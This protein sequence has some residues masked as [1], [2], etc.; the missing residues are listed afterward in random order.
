MNKH[1]KIRRE[2]A[3][4]DK[5]NSKYYYHYYI[6]VK[7]I[8][9]VLSVNGCNGLKIFKDLIGDEYVIINNEIY[10]LKGKDKIIK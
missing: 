3:K 4:Y 2:R 8:S 7:K 5:K 1:R 9:Y 6:V 10:Y